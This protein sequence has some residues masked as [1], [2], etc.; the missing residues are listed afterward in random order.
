MPEKTFRPPDDKAKWRVRMYEIIFEADTRE[1]KLFDIILIW[2][3]IL[4]V[5][6]VFLES[7]NELGVKYSFYFHLFEWIFTIL[8]SVEYIL[9]LMSVKRPH[10]Y[11][12]SFYGIVDFLAIVPTYLS[13]LIA[14]SQYLLV[15]RVLRLLRVFRVFKI[16]PLLAQAEILTRALKAS[17]S[18]IVVFLF[19]VLTMIVV[20][21]AIMYV[22]E[23]PENG[24][25]SIPTSMYWAI[26]TM[27]TVGYGD[28]SPQT[29][30]G[31]LLA[32]MVMIIG[33]SIIAVPTG[34]V[35]VEIAEAS[36]KSFTTQ[37]CPECL[38]EGHDRD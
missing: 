14:G 25:T 38:K 24:F 16:R 19:T 27:T 4:S 23:G 15:I 18:K 9:R 35:T 5:L 2:C 37:V 10:R 28:I 11:A 21:G 1:G 7:I 36:R 20:V 31:Q 12:F 30:I 17:R 34:I 13:L 26:V 33:Y 8:F 22:V 32:S 3:I 6:V 29:P